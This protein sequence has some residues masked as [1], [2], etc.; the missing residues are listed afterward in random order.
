MTMAFNFVVFDMIYGCNKLPSK[1]WI[2]TII[3]KAKI[4]IVGLWV[5][6]TITAGAPPIYGP[7]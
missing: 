7:I 3:I 5:R 4:P 1:N 2:T 6:P